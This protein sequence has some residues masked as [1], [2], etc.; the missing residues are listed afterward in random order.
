MGKSIRKA[1]PAGMN[2]QVSGQE[3]LEGVSQLLLLYLAHG[4]PGEFIQEYHGF[5][6][7]EACQL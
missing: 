3:V 1:L 6:Y 7:F 5:W 4:I 2:R